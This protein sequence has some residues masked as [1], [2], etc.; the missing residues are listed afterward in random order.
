MDLTVPGAS[1]PALSPAAQQPFPADGRIQATLVTP[2]ARMK[3]LPRVFGARYMLVGEAGVY[4]WMSRLCR[5]YD[6]GFWDYVDLSN[7]GFYMRLVIDKPLAI[8]VDGNGFDAAMSPD[9]AS[10]VATLFAINELLFKGVSHLDDSFYQLR[11]FARQH[12]QAG[13][14]LHAID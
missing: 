3:F 4:D 8:R 1:A 14:I 11:D 13:L 7:G 12:A 9:A 2:G 6:G 10:I 5:E